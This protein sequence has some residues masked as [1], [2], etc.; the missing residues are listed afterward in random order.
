MN[1]VSR[2]TEPELMTNLNHVVGFDSAKREKSIEAFLYMYRA[3]CDITKTKIIDLGCGSGK[4]LIKFAQ[5][6]PHV[7]II[8][9]DGSAEM[10]EIA[11]QNVKDAGLENRIEIKH[12]M[13][14]NIPI[15]ECDCVISSGTLHHSHDPLEFWKSIK[16]IVNDK[17]QIYVMDMLR[18]VNENKVIDIVNSL[19]KHENEYFKIDLYNS[20]KAAFTEHEIKEQL[21]QV[22]LA[23][24][25]V[26]TRHEQFGELVFLF[27]NVNE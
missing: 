10:V 3:M 27:R 9:Y 19:A 20:L 26:V 8:G 4:Y 18:P 17:T 6:F 23:L 14:L 2:I 7:V 1:L 12:S 5:E 16:R 24:K 13:F 22:G 15:T 21:K 25:I 11:K